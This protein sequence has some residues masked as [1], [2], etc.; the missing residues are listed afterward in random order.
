MEKIV[1]D[2][3][4][5]LK[6]VSASEPWII[7]FC[8]GFLLIITE[9]IIPALPLSVFITMNVVIF[10]PVIGYIMS[11]IATICG[12]LLS[13]TVFKKGFSKYLY[14]N[15]DKHPRT[16]KIVKAIEKISFSNLVVLTAIP[17]TPAFSINIGAGLTK[18]PFKKFLSMLIISKAVMVYFWAFV[19][20]TFVES[21]NDV[22]VLIKLVVV[23]IITF[24]ISK[25]VI[26]HFNVE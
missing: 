7:S 21:V 24:I 22:S 26:K 20:S 14:R 10:G 18:M 15:L 9:S 1:T 16:K 5:L 19:G 11:Y 6:D 25:V 12:C 8:F 2:L 3:V 23:L 13:Y 4:N 17:F